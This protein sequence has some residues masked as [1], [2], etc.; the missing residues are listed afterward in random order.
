MSQSTKFVFV[1]ENKSY[2]PW[3][4]VLI[5][6]HFPCNVI[7]ITEHNGVTRR[8]GNEI[9][10]DWLHQQALACEVVTSQ[11][12]GWCVCFTAYV[13]T[14]TSPSIPRI[15][16]IH[17]VFLSTRNQEWGWEIK[18]S[19]HA[20]GHVCFVFWHKKNQNSSV[21]VLMQ[22]FT[23]TLMHFLIHRIVSRV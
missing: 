5:Y 1:D 9:Q 10:I 8:S 16:R 12:V 4:M 23:T 17:W 21:A 2:G 3:N 14:F 6:N 22:L 7:S 15:Q 19:I 11:Y 18:P 20:I 13:I